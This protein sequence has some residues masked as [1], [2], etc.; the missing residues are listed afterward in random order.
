L[1]RIKEIAEK[2]IQIRHQVRVFQQTRTPEHSPGIR[3]EVPGIRANG[4]G[5]WIKR[6]PYSD[7][8]PPNLLAGMDLRSWMF[9]LKTPQFRPH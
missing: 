5:I 4:S 9:F 7:F 6:F 1:E 3:Q 8:S 2:L